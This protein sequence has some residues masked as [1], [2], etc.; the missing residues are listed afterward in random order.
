ML[1]CSAINKYLVFK[2]YS[3]GTQNTIYFDSDDI[4]YCHFEDINVYMNNI[5]NG[6]MSHSELQYFFREFLLYHFPAIG[7][8]KIKFIAYI[9][10][11]STGKEELIDYTSINILTKDIFNEK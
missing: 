1:D 4:I 7:K 11:K 9:G 10:N 6:I 3:F 2:G 8:Y 5:M